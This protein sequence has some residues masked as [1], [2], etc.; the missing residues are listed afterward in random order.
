VLEKRGWIPL[1]SR[2][3]GRC[4]WNI[5]GITTYRIAGIAKCTILLDMGRKR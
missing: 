3:A 5:A 1:D 4:T 2:A